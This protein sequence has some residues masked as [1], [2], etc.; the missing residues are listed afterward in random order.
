MGIR[1]PLLAMLVLIL[2]LAVVVSGCVSGSPNADGELGDSSGAGEKEG[3]EPEG[4]EPEGQEPEGEAGT[5][6]GET[7]GDPSSPSQVHVD[8][9]VSAT[10][11]FDIYMAE[12]PQTQVYKIELEKEHGKFQYEVEGFNGDKTYELKIDPVN[13]DVLEREIETTRSE[14]EFVAITKDQ[15]QKVETLVLEA[16][17]HLGD[18]AV[19]AEWS[20]ETKYGKT[21]LEVEMDKTGKS[22]IEYTYDIETGELLD[23]DY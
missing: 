3:Q 15:V 18:G 21:R 8:V 17:N 23:I 20:L 19:L 13:G 7:G 9:K 11:A 5:P 4:E 10:R 16:L 14:Q 1:K 6:E 2:A 12:F 22:D